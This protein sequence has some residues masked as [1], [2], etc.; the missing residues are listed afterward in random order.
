[1]N[2]IHLSKEQIDELSNRITAKVE[3]VYVGIAVWMGGDPVEPFTLEN[4]QNLAG[5]FL[6]SGEV[7]GDNP[8]R[9]VPPAKLLSDLQADLTASLSTGATPAMVTTLLKAFVFIKRKNA[10]PTWM[11]VFYEELPKQ[12]QTTKHNSSSKVF[13]PS[14]SIGQPSPK[15][16]QQ[17]LQRNQRG[18]GRDQQE[19]Q[20]IQQPRLEYGQVAIR[21]TDTPRSHLGPSMF[22][23]PFSTLNSYNAKVVSSHGVISPKPSSVEA[24]SSRKSAFI[25]LIK[26]SIQSR[27]Y[28]KLI[29]DKSNG[30]I[31]IMNIDPDEVFITSEFQFCPLHSGRT[32]DSFQPISMDIVSRLSSDCCG[33]ITADADCFDMCYKCVST[34]I[35]DAETA[36]INKQRENIKT[37]LKTLTAEIEAFNS[38]CARLDNAEREQIQAKQRAIV[39]K[40]RFEVELGSSEGSI[41]N[42]QHLITH[43]Y[44]NKIKK[45]N[46]ER[47]KDFTEEV[48]PEI[49]VMSYTPLSSFFDNFENI[50]HQMEDVTFSF[51]ICGVTIPFDRRY[52]SIVLANYKDARTTINEGR[53]K[54]VKIKHQGIAV[55]QLEFHGVN[56][57]LNPND[58]SVAMRHLTFSRDP[59]NVEYAFADISISPVYTDV[60]YQK[61]TLNLGKILATSLGIVEFITDRL[62]VYQYL[63]ACFLSDYS[64]I[65]DALREVEINPD[66]M[67]KYSIVHTNDVNRCD[68]SF[69]QIE[70]IRSEISEQLQTRSL[71]DLFEITLISDLYEITLMSGEDYEVKIAVEKSVALEILEDLSNFPKFEQADGTDNLNVILTDDHSEY[72]IPIDEIDS[73]LNQIR[74]NLDDLSTKGKKSTITEDHD[75]IS[76]PQ[77]SAL[78]AANLVANGWTENGWIKSTSQA[79][80]TKETEFD[81]GET[82]SNISFVSK[83]SQKQRRAAKKAKS[84]DDEK[85]ETGTQ[86]SGK[87]GITMLTGATTNYNRTYFGDSFDVMGYSFT[88]YDA[89][90]LSNKYYM[91]KGADFESRVAKLRISRLPLIEFNAEYIK[92]TLFA[93]EAAS[94]VPW[95]MEHG[96]NFTLLLIM[97]LFGSNAHHFRF[98]N[99]EEKKLKYQLDKLNPYTYKSKLSFGIPLS[100]ANKGRQL[101]K[102]ADKMETIDKI[103][104]QTKKKTIETLGA[105]I[106]DV[107]FTGIIQNG[108]YVNFE[109]RDITIPT[110][111]RVMETRIRLIGEYENHILPFIAEC[112]ADDQLNNGDQ[113]IYYNIRDFVVFSTEIP[114]ESVRNDSI[115]PGIPLYSTF[116]PN[117][118]RTRSI[119]DSVVDRYAVDSQRLSALHT[120]QADINLRTVMRILFSD[121]TSVSLREVIPAMDD[122]IKTDLDVEITANKFGSELILL[123]L[124][125]KFSQLVQQL[126]LNHQDPVV[127]NLLLQLDEVETFIKWILTNAIG[128]K[129]VNDIPSQKDFP[130]YVQEL[131]QLIETTLGEIPAKVIDGRTHH[132][133][134]LYRAFV[135]AFS[136]VPQVL[137]E[138]RSVMM[139]YV[140]TLMSNIHDVRVGRNLELEREI[141]YASFGD[142]IPKGSSIYDV[143]QQN[144]TDLISIMKSR[145]TDDAIRVKVG[146]PSEKL[147]V[148]LRYKIFLKFRDLLLA[149]PTKVQFNNIMKSIPYYLTTI[150][151]KILRDSKQDIYDFYLT[152]NL[153]SVMSSIHSNTMALLK[154]EQG[155]MITELPLIFKIREDKDSANLVA[156][157]AKSSIESLKIEIERDRQVL[158]DKFVQYASIID[159]IVNTYK[160]R[161]QSYDKKDSSFDDLIKDLMTNLDF[162]RRD[163]DNVKNLDVRIILS[164]F[165]DNSRIFNLRR[166]IFREFKFDQNSIDTFGECFT[167]AVGIFVANYKSSSE[168]QVRIL[169]EQLSAHGMTLE[170]SIAELE[171]K[172]TQVIN[173]VERNEMNK[174]FIICRIAQYLFDMISVESMRIKDKLFTK[175]IEKFSVPHKQSQPRIAGY[176]SLLN[177]GLDISPPIVDVFTYN[178]I[179]TLGKNINQFLESILNGLSTIDCGP[180]MHTLSDLLE[181]F[182]NYIRDLYV[183]NNDTQELQNV[184]KK[185]EL[186]IKVADKSVND[187]INSSEFDTFVNIINGTFNSLDAT[188][189]SIPYFRNGEMPY[190][191]R[192]NVTTNFF[193]GILLTIYDV[194]SAGEMRIADLLRHI[195]NNTGT[196]YS[197]ENVD[198]LLS[199]ISEM[200]DAVITFIDEY[201]DEKGQIIDPESVCELRRNYYLTTTGEFMNR[202]FEKLNYCIRRYIYEKETQFKVRVVD[203]LRVYIELFNAKMNLLKNLE[204]FI[205]MR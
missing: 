176:G 87:T 53:Y 196:E 154:Q 77:T 112:L 142:S 173:S 43:A 144:I 23:T 4:Y 63:G 194:I 85:S 84:V 99:E 34:V 180:G 164:I 141:K 16:H 64:E 96:D 110:A 7:R 184:R 58:S 168:D 33:Y 177:T 169:N 149:A 1:M 32:A 204:K 131:L 185:Y 113:L 109:N 25:N 40:K 157:K 159:V 49:P 178:D 22:F 124:T 125:S 44:F 30:H 121:V 165:D 101:R 151:K 174:T 28:L 161:K 188:I 76:R 59:N 26:E 48:P 98:P 11:F 147:D 145:K 123:S 89:E 21:T 182:I 105:E 187:I 172:L 150:A 51:T 195:S 97:V 126:K 203:R 118:I 156:S 167:S 107:V 127:T 6:K 119:F 181:H 200:N 134:D 130:G 190:P 71:T 67:R 38:K 39:E 47:R 70:S 198:S 117:A 12:P 90:I 86:I 160:S 202:M 3:N 82:F 2:V 199:N 46:T 139:N 132:L 73:F 65:I 27:P 91:I 192:Q 17:Q 129:A 116:N 42:M 135:D 8:E 152:T 94:E 146:F 136:G 57:T 128:R 75:E 19:P 69:I 35:D 201:V 205:M 36:E 140:I 138:R 45:I 186:F 103:M 95:F 122:I 111:G 189:S 158:I 93:E 83:K 153:G 108:Q 114:K 179:Q 183:G 18:K 72:V 10:A 66:R 115:I 20:R 41:Q 175:R 54:V 31:S 133:L 120:T 78:T 37:I 143:A 24:I 74:S 171:K 55:L 166:R 5:K 60:S 155:V 162:I 62:D 102:F 106:A 92:A 50:V 29:V 197:F 68:I 56:I 13:S 100:Q 81:F 15:I 104:I 163:Y 191:V 14:S 9:Y 193:R 170:S 137:I 80:D 61:L 88:G 79:L 52:T 148:Y